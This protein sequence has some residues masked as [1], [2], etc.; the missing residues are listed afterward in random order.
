MKA[1][2]YL[3]DTD[4]WKNTLL[5]RI[6]D[7]VE[8][9]EVKDCTEY[10]IGSVPIELYASSYNITHSEENEPKMFTKVKNKNGYGSCLSVSLLSD[11][12]FTYYY[13]GITNGNYSNIY[14]E[15]GNTWLALPV[16]DASTAYV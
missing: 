15:S 5:E 16:L 10:I 11:N 2:S 3:L 14:R 8:K 6:T 1:V 12:K 9:E 13:G 7:D 4:I